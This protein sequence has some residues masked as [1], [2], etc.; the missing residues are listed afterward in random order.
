MSYFS[1]KEFPDKKYFI[2]GKS[3]AKNLSVDLDVPFL[4]E[5]PIE[6][7]IREAG[8]FGRPVSLQ[9]NTDISESISSITRNMITQLLKR[10]K[11]LPPTEIVKITN[12]SGCSAIK[13]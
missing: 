8:D 9:K 3:G 11:N 13:K 6:E 10:N 2:F 4:G 12:M 1:P 5:I 7:T